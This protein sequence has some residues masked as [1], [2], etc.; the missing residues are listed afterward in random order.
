MLRAAIIG[1]GSWGRTLVSAVQGKTDEIRFVVG[2]GRTNASAEQ[3]RALG[4]D[5]VARYEDVL[6]RPDVDAVVLATPH[7]AHAD[8]AVL[9]AAAGKHIFV[10]KPFA[11]DKASAARAIDAAVRAKRVL[12]AGFN[13]RFHPSIA[14]LRA[15]V[16]GGSLGVLGAIT[17]ELSTPTMQNTAPDSWR[18]DARQAPGGA[19]PGL[20]VHVLD[21][22]ID[23]AGRVR[24][25]SCVNRRLVSQT[26]DDTSCVT[27]TFES[28]VT[29][30]FFCSIAAPF[31]CRLSAF[32]SHGIAEVY[33]F[34]LANFRVISPA[35]QPQQQTI[36]HK[37]TE[38]F[39][40]IYAELT[41]FAHSV[42]T[43]EP[44]P[45]PIDEVLHGVAVFDAALK[46]AET[47][48]PVLVS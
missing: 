35:M 31:N 44:Y 41:A 40:T 28:G 48:R 38:G 43:G 3:A 9:A 25:V 11:L 8:Q 10:E 27:L 24:E 15:Q 34:D 23:L 45:V 33:G 6:A 47:R 22:M 5:Y 21:G 16:R 19:M 12:A 30:L 20:G 39:D 7:P 26:T 32:G 17:A 46:S 2:H 1:M 37:V 29:G 36:E 4:I 42:R 14:A 13:R 18:M